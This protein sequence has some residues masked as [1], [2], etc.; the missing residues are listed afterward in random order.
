MKP[1]IFHPEAEAEFED[2]IDFYDRRQAGRGD[3]YRAE[4]EDAVRYARATPTAFALYKGGPAR[5]VIVRRFPF[6]VYFV[7]DDPTLFVVAVA[8]QR[9]QADYWLHRLSDI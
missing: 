3:D 6:A 4:V 8:D 1:Y 7:D 9:R 5:R 2:S